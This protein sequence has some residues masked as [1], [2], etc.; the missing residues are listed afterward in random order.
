MLRGQVYEDGKTYIFENMS[1]E[2]I[3]DKFLTGVDS[4]KFKR[5]EPVYDEQFG[6]TRY[7]K[8]EYYTLCIEDLAEKTGYAD[9]LSSWEQS[10]NLRIVVCH[11]LA[12]KAPYQLV[13]NKEQ[14]KIKF[15]LKVNAYEKDDQEDPLVY[16]TK[17]YEDEYR[18]KYSKKPDYRQYTFYDFLTKGIQLWEGLYDNQSKDGLIYD[19]FGLDGHVNVKI[20]FCKADGLPIE[21]IRVYIF[22]NRKEAVNKSVYIPSEKVMLDI[23]EDYNW[24]H[25]RSTFSINAI[26]SVLAFTKNF[27]GWIRETENSSRFLKTFTHEFGHVF[28]LYDAYDK[29]L[30]GPNSIK[31]WK[32]APKT[33]EVSNDNMMRNAKNVEPNDIEMILQAWMEGKYQYYFTYKELA[34][35]KVVRLD[36]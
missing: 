16:T 33:D 17:P 21:E 25:K 20:E 3:L 36:K 24:S 12:K 22:D 8:P 14:I 34:K 13:R 28:G 18:W 6:G 4:D 1:T 29:R 26:A 31:D 27:G 19:D 23:K 32:G 5:D 7:Y 35:S 9:I 10:D 30:P 2:T 11:A 15:Y